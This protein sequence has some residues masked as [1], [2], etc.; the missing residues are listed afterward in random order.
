[1][2]SPP[3]L[4][5]PSIPSALLS[6]RHSVR[7]SSM[8]RGNTPSSRPRPS[9]KL[10]WRDQSMSSEGPRPDTQTRQVL[11]SFYD[12][13]GPPKMSVSASMSSLDAKQASASEAPPAPSIMDMITPVK[14]GKRKKGAAKR[15]EGG[16][17]LAGGSG[18]LDNYNP[19]YRASMVDKT[20]SSHSSPHAPSRSP[21]HASAAPAHSTSAEDALGTPP[22]SE[23]LDSFHFVSNMLHRTTQVSGAIPIHDDPAL[24]AEQ[25][26]AMA[27]RN[28]QIN[29]LANNVE[30]NKVI[31][32]LRSISRQFEDIV[33][34][35]SG[36]R[37]ELAKSIRQTNTTYVRLFERM[38]FI[39]L[40]LSRRKETDT[41]AHIAGLR[42]QI[43]SLVLQN[44]L[45][46]A[47]LLKLGDQNS[48]LIGL[49]SSLRAEKESLEGQNSELEK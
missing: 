40:K 21:A 29:E 11:A 44:D 10:S 35:V 13:A 20:S 23:F 37:K 24:E 3:P 19:N 42:D 46:Q 43:S 28:E 5:L 36:H 18:F 26:T 39:V 16:E 31:T 25:S 12:D 48:A 2:A 22:S 49:N 34:S 14:K 45:L 6:P 38:L 7:P 15:K 27:K 47:Q 33:H 9:S 32:Q 41:E 17:G 4:P 8:E 1:M 30:M